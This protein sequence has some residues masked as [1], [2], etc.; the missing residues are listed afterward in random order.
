LWRELGNRLGQEGYWPDTAQDWFDI[1][2]RPAGVTFKELV[3]QGILTSTSREKRY[4]KKGFAT[5]S[6]KVELV[7]GLLQK[8]GYEPLPEYEEPGWSLVRTPELAQEYPLILISGSRVQH[9]HHST[10]RQL[11]SLRRRQPYPQLQIHPETAKKLN[12]SENDFVYIETPLG[13]IKQKAQLFNGIHQQVVHAD[14]YWWFPEQ[15]GSDPCLF[16]VWESNINSILPDG[17]E[18][19]D[20]S[21]DNNFRGLLCRVYRAEDL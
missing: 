21:G 16:G 20:Y 6:G 10:G 13:R 9:Y 5:F 3:E 14:G 12:I 19:S 8:L 4:L 15:P 2:L 1:L 17:L 18:H 11:K 7:S